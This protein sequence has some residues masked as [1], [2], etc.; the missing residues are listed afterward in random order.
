MV[1]GGWILVAVCVLVFLGCSEPKTKKKKAKGSSKETAT[2]KETSGD[3][4]APAVPSADLGPGIDVHTALDLDEKRVRAFS[5]L[6]WRRA[7]KS[8]DYL[9][10]YQ[11]KAQLAYPSVII[12]AADP[13][14]GFAKVTEAN[15][16]KFVDAVAAKLAEPSEGDGKGSLLKKPVAIQVGTH[17]AAGWTA[18]GEAKLDNL[19]K[20]IER[21]C[22][23]VVVNGRMYTVEAWAPVGKLDAKAKAAGHAVAAGLAVPSTDPIESSFPTPSKSAPEPPA[24]PPKSPEP[25][26]AAAKP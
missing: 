20:K 2:A 16:T 13:P 14:E 7:S 3:S 1:R 11:S 8:K 12:V 4:D 22:T 23:A 25:A 17:R 6:E 19:V 21:D 26:P 10:R 5:P 18:P 9:V 15:H 24:V